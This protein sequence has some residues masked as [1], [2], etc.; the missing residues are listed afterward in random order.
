MISLSTK[1]KEAIKTGLAIVLAYWIA[2]GAGWMNPVWAAIAVAMISLPTA[3]QSINKGVQRM[4]G[5]IPGCLAGIAIVGLAPQERWWFLALACA[6]VFFTT[7][8]MTGGKNAYAWNV[9]GFVGLII[10]QAGLTSPDTAFQQA[11]VRTVETAMGIAVYTLVVVFVWPHTNAGAIRK[12]ATGLLDCQASLF[13]AAAAR[14]RGA[15]SDEKLAP[16][17]AQQVQLL[18]GFAQA[19]VAEG[20]ESYEVQELRP[21]WQR[22]QGLSDG[23]RSTL[24][25]WLL[26]LAELADCDVEAVL[27]EIGEFCATLEARFD[28]IRRTLGGDPAGDEPATVL[29]TCDRAALAAHSHFERATFLAAWTGL[30]ELDS[31]TRSMLDCVRDLTGTSARLRAPRPAAKSGR[32][33]RDTSRGSRRSVRGRAGCPAPR[34]RRSTWRRAGRRGTARTAPPRRC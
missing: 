16:L 10:S 15:G 9:A 19:L 33:E 21:A 6:W 2:L 8:K 27:P 14:M 17:A 7:Y 1:A 12:A 20:S 4:V 24:D 5:T 23:T 29:L 30:K 3:G 26:G 34:R 11:V 28:Q 25:R 13:R 18:G 31:L 22:L 32:G